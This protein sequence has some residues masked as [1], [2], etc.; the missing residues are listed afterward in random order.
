MSEINIK[1]GENRKSFPASVS[2][3]DALKSVDRDLLKKS[4]AAKVNGAEVDLSYELQPTDV[5]LS[6]EPILTETRDGL[7]V[8]RHSAKQL[9]NIFY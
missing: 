5:V 9:I 4:L 3:A 6:I 8:I 7:E 1:I 2:V